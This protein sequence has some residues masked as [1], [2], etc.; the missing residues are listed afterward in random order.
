VHGVSGVWKASGLLRAKPAP[1]VIAEP[2]VEPALIVR[3]EDGESPRDEEKVDR[4]EQ[5]ETAGVGAT[6]LRDRVNM[7]D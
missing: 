7:Q 4:D 3:S 6:G 1:P 2:G 5:I